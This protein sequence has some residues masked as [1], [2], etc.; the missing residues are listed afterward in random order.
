MTSRLV[1]LIFGIICFSFGFYLLSYKKSFDPNKTL[2]AS[3]I[4]E[5]SKTHNNADH[6]QA[7]AQAP[8]PSSNAL[9]KT[10]YNDKGQCMVCHGEKG[11][12]NA[13]MQAPLL[14]GQHAW[15]TYSQLMEIKKGNRKVE[16]MAPFLE[17]LTE[18][19]LQAL[20]KY[21]EELKTL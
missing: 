4:P 11:E 13:D 1:V 16:A 20:S 9:G 18:E 21:I 7:P 5:S 10:I 17:P 12:G 3:S 19:E 15:Y 2:S 8:A 14:A 6:A